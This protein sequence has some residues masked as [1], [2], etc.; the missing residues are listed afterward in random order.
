MYT[1]MGAEWRQ[2]GFPRRRRPLSSVV[3]EEGVSERLVQDVKEF[4]DNPKWYS[5]RGKDLA[6]CPLY[7]AQRDS[8]SPCSHGC[9]APPQAHPSNERA[10]VLRSGLGLQRDKLPSVQSN[11]GNQDKPR[12][13][14]L[15]RR[16][17]GAGCLWSSLEAAAEKLCPAACLPLVS[18]RSSGGESSEQP[19]WFLKGYCLPR[20]P[21]PK[22]LPAVW[23]SRLR[24]KQ[25]H[26]SIA[27]WLTAVLLPVPALGHSSFWCEDVEEFEFEMQEWAAPPEWCLVSAF[28]LLAP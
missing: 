24:E 1:A 13:S 15:L 18:P 11:P 25:L 4:I 7:C 12:S 20:D 17:C 19:S 21:L 5:E 27:S 23:S 14:L 3:L 6:W 16:C 22:R 26:V 28:T 2:F 10:Q 8:L 9:G